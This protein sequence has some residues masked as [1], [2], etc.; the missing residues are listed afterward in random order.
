ML[1]WMNVLVRWYIKRFNRELDQVRYDSPACQEQVRSAIRA[2]PILQYLNDDYDLDHAWQDIPVTDYQRYADRVLRLKDDPTVKVEYFAQSSGTSTGTKKLIP[3]PE[4]FVRQ[5]HLRGSWYILNTLYNHHPDTNV[6]KFKNLLIG[7][8]IYER[9]KKYWIGDVSGIM[10]N[11]IP[12]FF[13]PFYV[14]TIAIATSPEWEGKLEKTANAAVNEE[15]ISLLAGVPTWV[16]S[17]LRK[18]KEKSG[19]DK[20]SDLWPGLLAYIH[21]G[22]SIEPYRSQFDQLIDKETFMYLEVYN[23]TEGFFAFQDDPESE[24]MLLMT[25]SGVYFEFIEREK[26]LSSYGLSDILSLSEVVAERE[27]VIV[28]ST[29]TGLIRYLQGDIVRFVSVSPY[30]I[31]VTGRVTEYINAFGEDLILDQAETALMEVCR[32]HKARIARYT[33]G[34]KYITIDQKGGHQ[35]Y[36]EFEVEPA[37]LERF[38]RDLDAAVRQA[39]SNYDQKRADDLALETLDLIQ[40]PAGTFREYILAHQ[41]IG[42]QSKV[43]KLRNDR[44]IIERMDKLIKNGR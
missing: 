5:N 44:L 17:L 43:Q 21:G 27:Y 9:N 15:Q 6:F 12:Q 19:K 22:V 23:A 42:A 37:D 33:V 18:V 31:K 24:G 32:S 3:T 11:R 39:N 13:R 25:K 35:W 30:R 14:P 40:V 26:Y 2:N 16:L 34:P 7:G 36:V 29:T 4:Y 10:L 8:A 28:I 41:R 20:I 38:S 1:S